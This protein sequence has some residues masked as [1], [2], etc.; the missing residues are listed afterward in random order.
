MVVRP[1]GWVVTSGAAEGV[2][3]FVVF[4]AGEGGSMLWL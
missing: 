3:G 1:V 4:K 2:G